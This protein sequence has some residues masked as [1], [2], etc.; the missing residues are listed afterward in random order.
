[1]RRFIGDHKLGIYTY[2]VGIGS[3]DPKLAMNFYNAVMAGDFEKAEWIVE[4]YEDVYFPIAEKYG[5]HRALK[6]TLVQLG[7]MKPFER[8]PFN[9]ISK[10]EQ[11]QLREVLISCGWVQ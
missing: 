3:F 10:N 8:A 5:W 11:E 7:I 9:R 6:E 2:L 1:M 4:K